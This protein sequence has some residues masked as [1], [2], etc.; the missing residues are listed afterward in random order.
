MS[1]HDTSGEIWI[2][3]GYFA[4][5]AAPRG[6]R[7]PVILPDPLLSVS[8]CVCPTSPDG[9]PS[10]LDDPFPTREDAEEAGKRHGA[11]HVLAASLRRPDLL[12]VITAA[13][14]R[15]LETPALDL[16]RRAE[17]TTR[18]PGG[19]G[20]RTSPRAS[21]GCVGYEIV[22]FT[23]GFEHSWL[24]IGLEARAHFED[25][26][27]PGPF[28]LLASLED[29]DA[30]VARLRRG[31]IPSEPGLWLVTRLEIRAL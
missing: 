25:G 24:C 7:S 14:E 26:I 16:V 17:L 11:T 21:E 27:T 28:G 19:E 2:C 9:A 29:A 22:S 10:A 13:D 15:G 4:V 20:A 8:R 6:G 30:L 18:S 5:Q 3:A 1:E 31:E 12:A 23:Y